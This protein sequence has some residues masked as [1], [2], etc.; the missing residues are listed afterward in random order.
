MKSFDLHA[1]VRPN[2]MA[3]KPYRS[4]RDDYKEGILLD[5]NENPFKT[6]WLE[7]GSEWNR[8]PDPHTSELRQAIAAYR[9]VK[10]ENIFTGNGSDEAID[11]IIRMVCTPGKDSIVITPPTYGMYKVS[12]GIHDVEVKEAALNVDFSLDVNLTLETSKN[13]KIIFLCSPNNPTGNLLNQESIIQIIENFEGLVVVD[14]A[15]IDFCSSSTVLPLLNKYPNL[16]VL[17]TLSKAFGLAGLRLGLAFASPEII[18]FFMRIKPPYNINKLTQKYAL[19]AF[20]KVSE[21]EKRAEAIIEERDRLMDALLSLEGV[22]K[23]H[24]SDAN[25]FLAIVENAYDVYRKLA[26]KGVIV[27][28]RGDQL[29]CENGLRIS[30][31]TRRENDA[32]INVLKEVL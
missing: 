12:A 21:V 17:Q 15:Y 1:M 28:Y 16:I 20:G 27:R 5:A 13:S 26:S 7:P 18:D 30:V 25:F 2:I 29:H 22:E 31:G 4:A 10:V 6:D 9:N 23:I 19:D 32:L 14:E 3:L 11:L 24:P 8:Y